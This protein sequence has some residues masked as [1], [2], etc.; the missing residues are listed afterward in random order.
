MPR[1]LI[2]VPTPKHHPLIPIDQTEQRSRMHMQVAFLP[3]GNSA[4][5]TWIF[6]GGWVEGGH[7]SR[8]QSV[9]CPPL[10]GLG[11]V[12]PPPLPY[13]AAEPDPG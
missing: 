13:L 2:L 10:Y 12:R 6:I 7:W 4:A 5:N 9:Q 8:G 11:R 3:R 1:S